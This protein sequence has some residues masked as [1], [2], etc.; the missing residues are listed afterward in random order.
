MN[1]VKLNL[2]F[3]I[4]SF[5]AFLASTISGV[6]LWQVL[7]YGQGFRGGRGILADQSFLGL[8]RHDWLDIHDYS[9]WIFVALVAI[10]IAL[11]WRWIKVQLKS[12]RKSP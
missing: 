4:L 10:H 1:R 8:A 3:D 6:V 9:S 5:F 11:H 7:P 12:I 2:L